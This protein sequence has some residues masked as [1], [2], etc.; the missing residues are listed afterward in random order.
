LIRPEVDDALFILGLAGSPRRHANS[1]TLLDAALRGAEESGAETEKI[2]ASALHKVTPCIN[3]AHCM[4]TGQCRIQDEMQEIYPKLDRADGLVVASPIYFMGVSAFLKVL[5][6]RCQCYWSRK[7]VLH[8]PLFPDNPGRVRKGIFLATGGHDKPVVFK[9]ARMTVKSL[10]DV[11]NVDYMDEYFA[12]SM[13][14]RDDIQ[15]VDGALDDVY[16]MGKRLVGALD[17][18]MN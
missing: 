11:L 14:E 7:Y 8:Q 4:K 2:I 5:V 9:G 1:E 18:A 12:T 3:C 16:G 15:K 13:E 17:E 6:D 10:F